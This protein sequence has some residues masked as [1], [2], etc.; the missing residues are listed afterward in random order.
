[1]D[2]PS[3]PAILLIDDDRRLSSM[4]AELLETEGFTCV[5]ASNGSRGVL[6]LEEHRPD[7]V[8]LDVMMPGQ[9]GIETLIEIR[10]KSNVPVIM[11]TALGD[12]KNRIR[13]LEAG[14]DDYVAK[15][16][17]ARELLL[18]IGAVL[19]RSA[20]GGASDADG[21]AGN[22]IAGPLQ[23]RLNRQQA[24]VGDIALDLTSTELRILAVLVDKN[25]AVVT[26]QYLSRYAIGRELLPDDRTLD[27][28]VSNLRRKIAATGD[29][30]CVIRT[31]RGSGYRLTVH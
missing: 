4:L 14:A 30:D 7:L 19:K 28:H 26:R 16:F 29:T 6:L 5:V 3:T 15:P 17:A 21:D 13:G 9:D 20:D 1:M 23:V 8:V 25:D 12:E 11:L 22:R 18:R 10:Q 24:S 2:T 27:T 31:V